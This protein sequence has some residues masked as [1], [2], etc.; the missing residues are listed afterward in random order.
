MSSLI[1]RSDMHSDALSAVL[2]TVTIT[3]F[4]STNFH[5]ALSLVAFIVFNALPVDCALWTTATT[6]PS[7]DDM[8]IPDRKRSKPTYNTRGDCSISS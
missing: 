5:I 4:L 7:P 8:N 1:S 6:K 3:V 2:Y